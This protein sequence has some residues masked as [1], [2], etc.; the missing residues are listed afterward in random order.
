MS[1]TNIVITADDQ[2]SREIR[3]VTRSLDDL[4]SAA[5]LAEKALGALVGFATIKGLIDFSDSITTLNNKL[6]NVTNS[7]EE[8]EAANRAVFDIAKRTA[9]PV[10]DVAQMFQRLSMAQD[11]VGLTGE[12][13]AKVTELVTKQMKAVGVSGAEASS[14][15][16][17]LSQAFGSGRLQGDEFRSVME[18]NPAILKL[19]AKEMG[20]TVGQ[21]K[22]LGS[23]GKITGTILRDAFLNNMEE[24][25][26]S[27][28]NRIPTISDGLTLVKTRAM[29]LWQEFDKTSGFSQA[30]GT[31]LQFVADH[32]G[33]LIM[34][35]TAFFAVLA[36]ERIIAATAAMGGLAAAVEV[37]NVALQKNLI[38]I[39]V[40]GLVYIGTEIYTS[41][42]KPLQ[43]AGV[44]AKEIGLYII[45][46]LVNA[47]V[48]VGMAVV[49]IFGAIPDV[50]A[51][52]IT[53]GAKISD[54]LDRLNQAI[55]KSLTDRKIK[56]IS[57]EEFAR[58]QKLQEATGPDKPAGPLT[59]KAEA[60]AL[61]NEQKNALKA[62]DEQIA[63]M[64]IAA[65]YEADRLTM[66]EH[67]AGL[68]KALSEEAEK[69][70]KHELTITAAQKERFTA[71]Y[72]NLGVAKSKGE[73]SAIIKDLALQ[74]A[75]AT[76]QDA[77]KRAAIVPLARLAA[78]YGREA[79]DAA[80]E[81]VEAGIARLMAAE[82]LTK[83]EKEGKA[84]QA[85]INSLAVSDLDTRQIEL[86]VE[87]ERLR[88]GDAWT[89]K[90]EDQLR[91][92]IKSQ[93]VLAETLALEKQRNLLTGAAT[94]QTRAQRIETATA[95]IGASDPRLALEQ[96]YATKKLAID[97]ALRQQE[98][99]RDA[100]QV[101]NYAT[102]L[103]AKET[104]EL[105]YLNN[106][107]LMNEQYRLNDLI[108]E[109]KFQDDMYQLKLKN[110][111]AEQL[112]RVQQQTG[113]QFGY[114]TQKQMADEA[115]KFQMKSDQE[116]YAFGLNQ[117]AS[118]FTSLGTYNKQAFEAAK[119][120]NIANAIMNTYTGA[121]KALATYPWPFGMI[122]AAAAVAAGLA[123][124]AA[125]RSQTYSGRALGGPM[126]G[127]QSYLVGEKGPEIFTPGTSGNMT[128]N[129]KIG[130]GTTNVTFN[131]VAN[132][133][134]GFDQ[135]LTSRR[136][137]ITSII[138]DAQLERG[139]RA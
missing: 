48:Q 135:L 7:T 42:I 114:D 15:L 29:E 58:I 8:F 116:K 44:T 102:V 18:A 65:Q 4:G 27:F 125:I 134:A 87:Q 41:L 66:S 68:K 81:E 24:I 118:M 104:L 55:S 120:F 51:A 63:K 13:V 76:E 98:L 130:G 94:P 103:K 77:V 109:Q 64:K 115:A 85:Q 34:A 23:E 137:L 73:V 67:E 53:P 2:A 93:Q 52:A 6:R 28:K 54:A 1:D 90:Q 40:A 121:T 31:A 74:T 126:V 86:A 136:G 96:D 82:N 60:P 112:L 124:V 79:A 107:A 9:A 89:K 119:A 21:L 131:I 62:F 139:R 92:N 70:K 45:D 75:Q 84:I 43:N 25:E 17:Q 122:A 108:K 20:V 106:R 59:K 88:L 61:T 5:S 30:L 22:Q 50:I 129:D 83:L 39:L 123:Q 110:A 12:G 133:T 97:E 3:N 26:A 127:G 57:D 19:V 10:A 95:V 132:D 47:F 138:S 32:L 33:S 46:S 78:R 35:T 113:T 100:G 36:V 72:N 37:L 117:A 14:Y 99:A 16:L 105:D 71:E 49:D 69:L 56:I 128:A 38:A 80:R 11:Q 111:Q 101:N 91:V